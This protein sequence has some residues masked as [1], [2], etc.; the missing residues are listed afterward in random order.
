MAYVGGCGGLRI[1]RG[2]LKLVVME[3]FRR[4]IV[5][6]I[7]FVALG[8]FC[9]PLQGLVWLMLLLADVAGVGLL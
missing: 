3:A 9:S 2:E 1:K 5:V 8:S 6:H 7:R 4:M